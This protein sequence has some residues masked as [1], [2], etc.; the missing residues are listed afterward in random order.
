MVS[1][2]V[3]RFHMLKLGK[4]SSKVSQQLEFHVTPLKDIQSLLDGE[5]MLTLLLQV[6][7]ASNHIASLVN[8][9]HQPIHWSA[10]NSALDLTI[11]TIL[12]LPEDI[13]LVSL[14]WVSKYSTTLMTINSSKKKLLNLTSDGWQKLSALI[15]MRLLSLRMYGPVEAI[16][17]HLLNISSEEWK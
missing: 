17:D 7:S 9:I 14:W 8:L 4:D 13:I 2:K 6:F 12:V 3:K 10:L 1:E 15:L 5:T 16:W 11:W